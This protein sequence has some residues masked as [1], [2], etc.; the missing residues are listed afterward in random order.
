MIASRVRRGF[1]HIARN[2][3]YYIILTLWCGFT[4]FVLFWLLYT[5]LKTNQE[6]F[7][8][9]WSL[10][11]A[12]NW[13]NYS[14]AWVIAHMGRYFSNSV[15]VV[16]ASVFLVLVISTPAAYV[17]TR[18]EFFGRDFFLYLF[19]AGLGIPIQ[20]LLVPLYMLLRGIHGID[21][22]W[23]LTLVYVAESIPFTVLLLTGFMRTLPTELE[24]AAALDGCS[25]FGIFYRVMLPLSQPGL[26]ATAIFNF[27]GTW[28][29]YLLALILITGDK[30]R[31]LP[32]GIYNLRTAMQYTADWTGLFAGVVI[33]MIPSI[34]AFA[35]LSERIMSG[36]TLGALKG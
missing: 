5:S 28:S 23:G 27:V 14:K 9:T 15:I 24:E 31:T 4:V 36:L 18:I 22:L 34:V 1:P 2:L 19:I 32:L 10:P 8:N 17:L 6:L 20:L 11:K 7:A 12:L 26:I 16:C 13:A 21:T 30:N 35:L 3:P 25:E 33:V 29:E